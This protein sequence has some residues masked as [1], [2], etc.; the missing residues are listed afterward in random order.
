MFPGTSSRGASTW[1]QLLLSRK[2]FR[3]ESI[4]N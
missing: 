4:A 3:Q 1:P 2:A